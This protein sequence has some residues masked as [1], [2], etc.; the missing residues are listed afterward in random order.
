MLVETHEDLT[1]YFNGCYVRIELY[2]LTEIQAAYSDV[3]M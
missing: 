2:P 3:C 1:M